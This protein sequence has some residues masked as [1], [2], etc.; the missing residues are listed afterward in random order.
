[1]HKHM[2]RA[3]CL[4][5][6]TGQAQIRTPAALL[7][8]TLRLLAHNV[9]QRAPAVASSRTSRTN[10]SNGTSFNSLPPA[11]AN[12]CRPPSTAVG[13]T[14]DPKPPGS[15]PRPG[16]PVPLPPCSTGSTLLLYR[17]SHGRLPRLPAVPLGVVYVLPPVP[18]IGRYVP[19]GEETT[20]RRL[21]LCDDLSAAARMRSAAD[22]ARSHE[23]MRLPSRPAKDMKV[24]AAAAA[25]ARVSAA[26]VA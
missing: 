26:F 19:P 5:P 4:T 21:P 20:W 14:R 3:H 8:H 15:A 13:C 12:I 24:A 17:A 23:P 11:C 22:A 18:L 9:T 7:Q 10:I 16:A 25:A 2:F 6:C 1:V